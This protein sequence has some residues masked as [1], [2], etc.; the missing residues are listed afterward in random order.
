VALRP[1]SLRARLTLWYTAALGGLLVLLGVVAL[2]LLDRGLRHTVDVSLD[3]LARTVAESSRVPARRGQLG[4]AL[5]ALVGPALAERFYQLLDPLGRPDPRLEPGRRL[6]LP[7]SA[8]TLRNAEHGQETFETVRL[9]GT[10]APL[11]VLTAPVIDGGQLVQLVQVA[12]SLEVVEAARSRFLLVLAGLLPVAL[13]AAAAGGWFLAGR[14]LRP[15]DAMVET[16]RRIGAADLARRIT[17]ETA[18]DELGRLAAVLNDMLARL[19]RSF[20]AA[21]QFSADA[22]HELRT[23]LTILKGE[24]EVALGAAAPGAPHRRTLESCLEEVDRLAGLVEDL[25]FLARSDAGALALSRER[26]DLTAV[27]TDAAPALEALAGKAGVTFRVEPSPPLPV[28]GSAPLLFRVVF[29]LAE[30]AVKH[31][32]AG[33]HVTVS[34]QARDGRALLEVG[35]DGP[36]IPP[37]DRER[38]FDRFYRGDPARERG[39]SGLGL[40]LTRAIVQLH[41]GEISVTS[42]PGAGACFRVA[43]PLAAG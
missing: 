22:A 2:V 35:D 1:R 11:R 24:L 15:V 41:G 19:E 14:A 32:G 5:A 43:L 30:N 40:P 28:Q 6:D 7:L 4:D 39:G 20:E 36:G 27:V 29:N 10:P 34:T 31:A 23:P 8:A 33:A 37:A 16:A 17:T 18:D 12:M 25:L 21:R 3:S 38:I 26:V 42:D 9:P 13:A